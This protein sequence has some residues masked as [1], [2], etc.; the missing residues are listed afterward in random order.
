MAIG[1]SNKL[2][3]ALTWKI[4]YI[5]ERNFVLIISGIVGII[6]GLAAIILKESVHY[7]HHFLTAQDFSE[8]Y[9]QIFYPL[10]GLLLTVLLAK[11]LYREKQLGHAITDILYSISRK[12]SIMGKSKMYSRLF[13]SAFTVGF[14]GSAGLESPIVLTGS[15]IG[16]NI[17]QI[18]NL[19]Y[20]LRTLMIGC[21]TA[22][23][24][25]AIFNAPIAGLIFSMEVILIEVSVASFIPLLVASVSATLV[26]LVLLGEDVLFSFK[27]VDTFN[28]FDTPLYITLGVICGFTSIYFLSILHKIEN[29]FKKIKNDYSTVL[30]GGVLLSI[31]IFIVPAVYGEGY[32]II[33]ALLNNDQKALV[34]RSVFLNPEEING[35]ILCVYLIAIVFVKAIASSITIGCGGSGGTFAPSLFLGGVTGYAFAKIINLSEL[36]YISQSNFALVG[37]CGVLCGVQSAPLTAIF[38]IAELTGGYVLFIP[39]MIVSALSFSTVSYFQPYSIY[40]KELHT[41]GEYTAGDHDK[42]ILSN[43]NINHLIERDFKKIPKSALLTDL[44]KII[45]VSKRNIFPVIDAEERLRGI[46]TLD[47]VREIMFDQEKQAHTK[48][49][50]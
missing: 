42:K 2:E 37:M 34:E 22:G 8:N 31:I 49:S 38:L 4:K 44:I 28:A 26:S 9:Y 43:L 6:S 36:A 25:S 11:L 50:T 1:L 35:W 19:N 5:S 41:R 32:E 15:A 14:G 13:T 21:G 17:A 10:I 48:I 33:K 45:S 23:V 3:R 47:D 20:K 12:S 29:A 18:V 46:V 7:I 27:L 30:V 39:L 24:I 16:S 40:I